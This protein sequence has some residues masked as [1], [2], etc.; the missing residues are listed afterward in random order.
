MRGKA[1]G[2]T[3]VEI[4]I[5]FLMLAVVGGVLLQLFQ[6]GLRN[7][8]Q[9]D[10][11]SH[12]AMLASSKLAELQAASNLVAAKQSGEFADGFRWRLELHPYTEESGQALPGAPVR[13]LEAHLEI[14]WDEEDTPYTY[15]IYT[16]FLTRETL[17]R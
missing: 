4:L 11:Y 6:G 5:A 8:R 3:L 1:R 17:G 14:L 10:G 16:L 7:V 12:A 9:S 13:L 15:A 2:F